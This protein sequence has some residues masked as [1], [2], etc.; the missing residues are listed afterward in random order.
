MTEISY[1]R[2]FI[3]NTGLYNFYKIEN[4]TRWSFS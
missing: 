4:L 2:L 3:M 1:K